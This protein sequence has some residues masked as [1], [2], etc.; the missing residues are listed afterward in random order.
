MIR[1]MISRLHDRRRR[2]LRSTI[3]D[4]S[5]LEEVPARFRPIYTVVL[6]VKY[7][8]FAL[9]GLI[10]TLTVVPTIV[11]L[12]SVDYGDVWT[13]MVGL[14]GGVCLVGLVRRLERL[15]LYSL[16]AL[17][18]GFATY[19]IGA[20]ILWLGSGDSDRAALAV[21]LWVFLILPMWRVSDLIHTIR[22]RREGA[23]DA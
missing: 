11:T 5:L 12:T 17:I 2:L 9:F 4:L 19:P 22:L 14:T 3:W 20:L 21:G 15:E 23:E 6:P 16:I 13:A 7:T 1:G 18:I 10:G 8:L